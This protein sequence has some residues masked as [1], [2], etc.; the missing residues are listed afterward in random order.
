MY[1]FLNVFRTN[2]SVLS[3]AKKSPENVLHARN[4]P[5]ESEYNLL[6]IQ[7]WL[8]LRAQHNLYTFSR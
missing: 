7:R 2:P 3:I 5:L 6:L 1:L 8:V 4:G